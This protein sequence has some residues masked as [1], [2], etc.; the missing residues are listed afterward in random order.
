ML[1]RMTP[2]IDPPRACRQPALFA[3]LVVIG[4]ALTTGIASARW[5]D[6]AVHL[7]LAY[8]VAGAVQHRPAERRVVGT[9]PTSTLVCLG[10]D[11]V[12]E[13][14]ARGRDSVDAPE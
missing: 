11:A 14:C 4:A 12:L 10:L 3:A 9:H 1:T 13:P 8:A 7:P 2:K 6:A 5:A